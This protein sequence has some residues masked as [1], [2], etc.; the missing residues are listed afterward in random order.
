MGKR[1][2]NKFP[3]ELEGVISRERLDG[4]KGIVEDMK[5]KGYKAVMHS[6]PPAGCSYDAFY[7]DFVPIEDEPLKH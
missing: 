2:K 6:R 3:K 5:A 7:I 1:K 4:L